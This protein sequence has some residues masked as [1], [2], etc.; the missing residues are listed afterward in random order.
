MKT[1]VNNSRDRGFV[2][3]SGFSLFDRSRKF[4]RVLG[5]AKARTTNTGQRGGI[6]FAMLI[7]IGVI[8]VML[9][10]YIS[11]VSQRARAVSRSQT[12][13][14]A[15]PVAEAGLED[16]MAHLNQTKGR[17]IGGPP[18]PSN[19]WVTVGANRFQKNWPGAPWGRYTVLINQTNNPAVES[20]GSVESTGL[21]K[22]YGAA[23]EL[24]RRFRITTRFRPQIEGIVAQNKVTI[25]DNVIA[26]SYDS[27]LGPYS[28]LTADDNTF[29]GNN[30]TMA[31][32]MIVQ[33][34]AKLYGSAGAGAITGIAVTPP[35]EIGDKAW[36]EDG[37]PGG[38]QPGH[39]SGGLN[40]PTNSVQA[41]FSGAGTAPTSGT[42]GGTNY[43]YLLT[44]GD[45]KVVPV[46][47]MQGSD[48][49]M[50]TQDS[51]L[52]VTDTFIIKGDAKV[53]IAPGAR[54]RLYMEKQFYCQEN[55]QINVA[56]RPEQ[57]SYYGLNA[58]AEVYMSGFAKLNGTIYAP[59]AKMD[60]SGDAQFFGGGSCLELVMKGN[61][62]FHYDESLSASREQ[63]FLITSWTEL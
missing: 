14:V 10:A 37:L 42:Y 21:V 27:R 60:L 52:W 33:G 56:G 15:V 61:F 38:A 16:A 1:A 3:C 8:G 57:F 23:G 17:N 43:T 25:Q 12:W 53:F 20:L 4:R 55:A 2:R 41:P 40:V 63:P 13:N 5:Q 9:I 62:K 45:Y 34:S 18:S 46:L 11:L 26:D 28:P 51:T 49:M 50:V 6:L 48:T 58:N 31:G 7:V 59:M 30:S 35:A 44:G 19:G 24:N 29:I 47:T 36:I 32:Q 22:V 54:L 39:T